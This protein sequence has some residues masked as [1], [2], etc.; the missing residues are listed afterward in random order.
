MELDKEVYSVKEPVLIMTIEN[1]SDQNLTFGDPCDLLREEGGE[2]RLVPMKE[3]TGWHDI[4]K[5]DSCRRKYRA[6]KWIG[7]IYEGLIPEL[8]LIGEPAVMEDEDGEAG[9]SIVLPF[10]CS[11]I[12]VC[13]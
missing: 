13:G 12:S 4:F 5:C 3:N 9:D 8:R 2:Y 1:L 7:V 11:Y 6:V 10:L